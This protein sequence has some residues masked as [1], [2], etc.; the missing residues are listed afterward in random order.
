MVGFR[1]TSNLILAQWQQTQVVFIRRRQIHIP[2]LAIKL[3][4]NSKNIRLS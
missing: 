3:N 1:F 2:N 4:E